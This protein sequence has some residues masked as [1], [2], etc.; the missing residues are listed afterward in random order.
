MNKNNI[1][2]NKHVAFSLS[3]TLV[4]GYNL[5]VCTTPL[6]LESSFC[7]M[8]DHLIA[9]VFEASELIHKVNARLMSDFFF[10]MPDIKLIMLL[11]K[12]V[13]SFQSS[14]RGIAP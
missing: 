14:V 10:L 3:N 9:F 7:I 12:F 13:G 6:I 8:S 4:G 2:P 1:A 5:Q 11:L